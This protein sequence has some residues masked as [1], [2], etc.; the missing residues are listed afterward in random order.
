MAHPTWN[1]LAALLAVALVSCRALVGIADLTVADAAGPAADA[2]DEDAGA[3]D[4]AP[5]AAG[6][7]CKT[8]G[9]A[10]LFCADFDES[11]SVTAG[12]DHEQLAGGATLALD[13]ALSVSRP[14]SA[15]SH[16]LATDG[17]SEMVGAL[18]KL[19]ASHATSVKLAYDLYVDPACA[20]E[21]PIALSNV[22]L[23]PVDAIQVGLTPT[24]YAGLF[25]YDATVQTVTLQGQQAFAAGVW[26]HLEL[27]IVL[28]SD[29]GAATI[30]VNGSSVPVPF[31]PSGQAFG[32]GAECDLT[33]G[34]FS[35]LP[36]AICDVHYDNVT[37]DEQ[38]G[39]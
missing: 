31:V 25:I 26:T 12:W 39:P 22:Q 30:H 1:G 37:F 21:S 13:E 27:D 18:E 36:R 29:A 33:V 5:D 6:F 24:G 10:H 3:A 9:A 11:P 15:H 23:S 38:T 14:A 7:F 19:F 20:A 34:P 32:A 2:S 16:L 8:D 28:A 17:G 4:A 35:D